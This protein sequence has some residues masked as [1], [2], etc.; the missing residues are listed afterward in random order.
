MQFLAPAVEVPGT[1]VS[2]YDS[3]LA[4]ELAA[5]LVWIAELGAQVQKGDTVARLE[6][7]T[8]KIRE[9]E[10]QSLVDRE[11]L[12]YA[13]I[14]MHTTHIRAPFNGVVT[15]RLRNIG[16]RLNVADEIVRLVDPN[17]LEVI[18]RAPLSTVNFVTKADVLALANEFPSAAAKEV[19][20]VPRD[21]LVLRR[22][23]SSVFEVIDQATVHQVQVNVGL[24]TGAFIEVF[25]DLEAGS[26]VVVR[27]AE[28]LSEGMAIVVA[29]TVVD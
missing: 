18:A 1:V 12:G 27:G 28:G 14:A 10:A 13:Q 2:R 21:A 7:F 9:M 8:Y 17:S 23:G 4:S 22:D 16:E 19:L 20:A 11:Q 15:A 25:G 6:D 3:R 24:G 26:E 5:K 29:Q